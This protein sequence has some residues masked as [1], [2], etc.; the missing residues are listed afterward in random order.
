MPRFIQVHFIIVFAFLI[1]FALLQA[2]IKR[3]LRVTFSDSRYASSDVWRLF[4]WT[5]RQRLGSAVQNAGLPKC[6][7]SKISNGGTALPCSA[8][9]ILR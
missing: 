9:H 5:I 7:S 3:V 4:T 6:F 2:E 1:G 8:L